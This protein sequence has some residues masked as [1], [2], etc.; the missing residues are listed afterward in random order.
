MKFFSQAFLVKFFL[1]ALLCRVFSGF[2]LDSSVV[3]N[4]ERF[5]GTELKGDNYTWWITWDEQLSVLKV[6]SAKYENLKCVSV[7]TIWSSNP[8]KPFVGCAY[9]Y[10]TSTGPAAEQYGGN[11]KIE[12]SPDVISDRQYIDRFLISPDQLVLRGHVSIKKFPFLLSSVNVS[13]EL[14][15][16]LGNSI[17]S[18]IG[19]DLK[20]LDTPDEIA[21]LQSAKISFI[22][23]SAM[24]SKEE[25][26]YGFGHQYSFINMKGKLLP[27]LTREQG[28]GRGLEP[29]TFLQNLL[30]HYGGG[31][32]DTTYIAVPQYVTSKLSSLYLENYD[33]CFFDLRE[34]DITKVFVES[35]SLNAR[36]IHGTSYFDIISSYTQYTG[37]M[38]PLPEWITNG[39]V[40]GMEGGEEFLLS[41]YKKLV[42]NDVPISAFWLQDWVGLRDAPWGKALWW[43]WESD[44]E[45]YPNW[46][47][48]VKNLRQKGIRMMTYVNPMFANVTGS[49][50]FRRSLYDE[51]LSKNFSTRYDDGSLEQIYV[52]ALLLDIYNPD[53]REWMK[54]IIRENVLAG[55]VTG[56]M[57]DFGEAYPLN[58][59]RSSHDK[60]QY[61][62]SAQMHN[63]YPEEWAKLNYEVAQEF[64]QEEI[65]F[66]M[67]SGTAKSMRYTP[68][69]W[70]GDQMVTWDEYDGIKSAVVGLLNS[71]FSGFSI[72][73]TDIGGYQAVDQMGF[74]YVRSKELFLRWAEMA[75]FSAV[76]RTHYGSNPDINWQ[77]NS[78]DETLKYYSIFTKMYVAWKDYRRDL[79]KEASQNGTPVNRH[80]IFHYP[81]DTDTFD[82]KYQYMI[83]SEWIFAPVLDS[84]AK[85]VRI[86][87]PEGSW[88]HVWNSTTFPGKSWYTVDAPLGQPC[89]FY[90]S[91]TVHGPQFLK[92]FNALL[93]RKKVVQI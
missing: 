43:N 64:P 20:L 71:G 39:S 6:V 61:K 8:G 83:G 52:N 12:K 9:S 76:F 28:N 90:K 72:E 65:V 34:D 91:G 88:V 57:C 33:I 55:G 13:Y 16:H 30:M 58:A 42:D 56:Y 24:S 38:N 68:L 66:F 80:L 32:W 47:S 17:N 22:W 7:K 60:T 89:L 2:P 59:D 51:V 27:I 46:L 87:L 73:H 93:S 4:T 82:L 79:I 25:R 92:N 48:V 36:I 54:K 23:I 69:M 29:L 53:A 1:L 78:D 11:F 15:F 5:P 44:E 77:L 74:H 85:S 45:S 50:R 84:G 75:A 81:D 26:F 18:Q 67:R 21:K 31:S 19:L 63:A 10:T 14:K 3:W 70:L 86:Y 35:D 41:V 49:K 40:V 62:T 37:R